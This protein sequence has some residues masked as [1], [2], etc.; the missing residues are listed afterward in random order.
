MQNQH[1]KISGYRE[2]NQQEVDLMNEVKALGP[3]LEAVINKVTAYVANQRY[4]C[5]NEVN[6]EVFN[7]E[8]YE[9]LN[10][11]NPEKFIALATDNF[12]IGLMMLTRAVGQQTTF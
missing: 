4:N 3:Q 2:L 11:A 6:N 12:Q 9:R 7:L 5:M 10:K 1:Q 8:E